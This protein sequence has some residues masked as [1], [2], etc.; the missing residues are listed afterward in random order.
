M[1]G[2]A[3]VRLAHARLGKYVVTSVEALDRFVAEVTEAETTR[4]SQTRRR[5]R[6]PAASRTASNRARRELEQVGVLPSS[7]AGDDLA[8]TL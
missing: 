4:R 6:T 2:K 7:D 1:E 8:R 3:G 5:R